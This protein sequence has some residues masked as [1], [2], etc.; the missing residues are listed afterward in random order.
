MALTPEQRETLR[1]EAAMFSSSR[2][3]YRIGEL[4]DHLIQ[5]AI[6]PIVAEQQRDTVT[7]LGA[8]LDQMRASFPPPTDEMGRGFDAGWNS[9]R[10]QIGPNILNP[11][12]AAHIRAALTA[13]ESS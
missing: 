8:R 7:L 9:A 5:H 13:Q 1:T 4:V 3:S 12:V 6:E 2:G 11:R 10:L